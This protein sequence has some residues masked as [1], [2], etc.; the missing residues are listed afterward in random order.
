VLARGFKRSALNRLLAKC[1]LGKLRA[2]T[3][4]VEFRPRISVDSRDEFRAFVVESQ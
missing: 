2:L 3:A 4:R 1:G